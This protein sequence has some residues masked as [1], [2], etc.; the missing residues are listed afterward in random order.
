LIWGWQWLVELGLL[1]SRF[2]L[3]VNFELKMILT[4]IKK[5]IHGKD[6]PN[7]LDQTIQN[8]NCQILMISSSK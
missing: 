7:L 2:L 5:I 6:V 4:G 1:L 3:L 8:P